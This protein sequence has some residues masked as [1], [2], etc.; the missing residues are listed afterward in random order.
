MAL[1]KLKDFGYVQGEYWKIVKINVDWTKKIVQD[2][3][4]A[5]YVNEASKDKG[6]IPS[7]QERIYLNIPFSEMSKNIENCYKKIKEPK[8]T[9]EVGISDNGD[10][11]EKEV[12]TQ[13]F[14]S[15]AID[16]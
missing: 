10:I 11:L 8:I 4:V 15:E 7:S 6:F 14:W 2:V 1:K 5:C 3:V 16:C 13:T 9:K 12:I